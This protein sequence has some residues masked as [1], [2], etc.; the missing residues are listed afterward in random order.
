[1]LR[2]L[3]TSAGRTQ[4]AKF[5]YK[6]PRHPQTI[7]FHSRYRRMASVWSSLHRRNPIEERDGQFSPDGRWVAYRSNKSGRFEVYVQPLQSPGGK[8]Q[9]STNGGTQPRWRRDG[10]EL[11]YISLDYK[12][13]AVPV[14]VSSD[15]KSIKPGSPVSLFP[16]TIAGGALPATNNHQY[17]VRRMQPR[18]GGRIQPATPPNNDTVCR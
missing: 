13:T 15:G 4:P 10:K 2:L 11:F 5:D 1:L 3:C 9:I 14:V 8:S 7:C 12:L 17:A 16:V 6:L 18:S